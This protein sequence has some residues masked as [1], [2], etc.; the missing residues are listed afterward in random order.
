MPSRILHL[1]VTERLLRT[2]PFRDPARLRIGSVIPDAERG[3]GFRQP[4]RLFLFRFS[5]CHQ[6]HA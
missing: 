2:L 3:A 5:G 6:P 4:F 1:A